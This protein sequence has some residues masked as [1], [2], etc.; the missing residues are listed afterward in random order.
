MTRTAGGDVQV[1]LWDFTITHPG[2]PVANQEYF[3][4][5]LPA[6]AKGMARVELQSLAPGT[7]ALEATRVGYRENDVHSAYRDLGTPSQLTRREVEALRAKSDGRPFLREIVTVGADGRFLKELELRENDVCLLT[8]VR[9]R[10][11]GANRQR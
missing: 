9:L 6:R 1:L 8:L 5:D 2:E 10:E 4:R 11:E 3:L 7:Y